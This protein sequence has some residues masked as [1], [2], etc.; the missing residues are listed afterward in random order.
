MTRRTTTTGRTVTS[1]SNNNKENKND[2]I[3]TATTTAAS[4]KMTPTTNMS[5]LVFKV[6]LFVVVLTMHILKSFVDVFL[7]I[8][9]FFITAIVNIITETEFK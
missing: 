1:E 5:H 6:E 7:F 8:A 9:F 3:K 4:K 2:E